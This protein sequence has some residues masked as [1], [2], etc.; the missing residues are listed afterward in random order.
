[1]RFVNERGVG[2]HT[3]TTSV[4][5]SNNFVSWSSHA[6]CKWKGNIT[7]R[8]EKS[9]P[10]PHLQFLV[11]HRNALIQ[12]VWQRHFLT[13]LLNFFVV[14]FKVGTKKQYLQQAWNIRPPAQGRATV[15]YSQPCVCYICTCHALYCSY[16]ASLTCRHSPSALSLFLSLCVWNCVGR[17]RCAG[18][19][20]DPHQLQPV[21]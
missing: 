14:T 4:V 13:D 3:V 9:F 18:D 19:R 10:S 21:Q 11:Q 17:D 2:L 7:I 12:R 8:I 15:H 16:C 1:M 20:A 5:I 6:I